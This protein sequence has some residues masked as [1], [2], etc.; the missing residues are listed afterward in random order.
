[1]WCVAMHLDCLVCY[2][3]VDTCD[4]GLLDLVV[5]V[6]VDEAAVRDV[7]RRFVEVRWPH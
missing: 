2:G 3:G 1:M 7:H 4:G 6:V 5:W